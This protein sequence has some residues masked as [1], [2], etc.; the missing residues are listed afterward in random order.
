VVHQVDASSNGVSGAPESTPSSQL[1]PA[2][3]PNT[4]LNADIIKRAISDGSIWPAFQPLVDLKSNAITGFEVLARWTDKV[5]GVI[6][7]MEFIPA[8]EVCGVIDE[9]S[10]HII[11]T[12]CRE[13]R[14]WPGQFTLAFN[15]SPLQSKIRTSL[16]KW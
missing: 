10:R 1:Y 5:L 6:A 12:A 9:L 16:G 3:S 14:T 15:I 13:A 4:L 7:P 2:G 11:F 8:A